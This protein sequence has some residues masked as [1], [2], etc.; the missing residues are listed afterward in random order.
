MYVKKTALTFELPLWVGDDCF[1]VDGGNL[2]EKALKDSFGASFIS[3]DAG[4]ESGPMDEREYPTVVVEI[5]P[6]FFGRAV[7]GSLNLNSSSYA[8]R[9]ICHVLDSV[10]LRLIKSA[11]KKC[12][13]FRAE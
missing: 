10:V 9:S 13:D 5:I 4:S 8:E 1:K 7:I 11:K 6:N 12:L 3:F 2:I